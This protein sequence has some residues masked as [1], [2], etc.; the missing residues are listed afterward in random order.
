[1]DIATDHGNGAGRLA[2]I[3]GDAPTAVRRGNSG[4]GLWRRSID[5]AHRGQ[6]L[7]S[8]CR[9]TLLLV[10]TCACEVSR[11]CETLGLQ[12]RRH[13][14]QPQCVRAEMP[15][16]ARGPHRSTAPSTT[17]ALHRAHPSAA[18]Q[19]SAQ[20]CMPLS[21]SSEAA[22]VLRACFAHL[23]PCPIR[24]R[25]GGH[26]AVRMRC[27]T[28]T[29]RS[30][31]SHHCDSSHRQRGAH[32]PSILAPTAQT[33]PRRASLFLDPR[34]QPQTQTQTAPRMSSSFPFP[35][36]PNGGPMTPPPSLM[37]QKLAAL[38]AKP[39]LY[40]LGSL[41][42]PLAVACLGAM[43]LFHSALVCA[44]VEAIWAWALYL[45]FLAFDY[46][47]T[48]QSGSFGG[49]VRMDARTQLYDSLVRFHIP[50]HLGLV[51]IRVLMM[52]AISGNMGHTSAR[53]GRWVAGLNLGYACL[54]WGMHRAIVSQAE[55]YRAKHESPEDASPTAL[56]LQLY[57]AAFWFAGLSLVSIVWVP[58][59]AS[60]LRA[61]EHELLRTHA[62]SS[63]SGER[64][65]DAQMKQHRAGHLSYIVLQ[66]EKDHADP[67]SEETNAETA[68]A[69]AAAAAVAPTPPGA[70]SNEV[71]PAFH[72]TAVVFLHG[73]GAG[74]SFWFLNLPP[75]SKALPQ[76]R[77]YAVDLAGMGAS[78][79]H[80]DAG[81]MAH[82]H[83]STDAEAYF[84]SSLEG[85][86]VR[87]GVQKMILV[88]HSFGGYIAGCYAM[89]Y[90]GR[91]AHLILASPVGLPV[92]EPLQVAS[93]TSRAPAWLQ[94]TGLVGVLRWLWSR[95][96]TLSEVLHFLGPLG[97]FAFQWV[98]RRRFGHL[99][100]A[101]AK[102]RKDGTISP[103]GI[104]VYSM[105]R[106]L[107]A[108]NA[109]PCPGH[110][111]LSLLLL[112]GA[113]AVDPLVPRLSKQL[114]NHTSL[115][116]GS[117]DWMD[118]GAGEA[119]VAAVRARTGETAH[120]QGSK[121]SLCAL[122]AKPRGCPHRLFCPIDP[123]S[124]I[125]V[126]SLLCCQVEAEVIVIPHAGHQLYL[127]NPREF[128][129]TIVRIVKQAEAREGR[130]N[131]SASSSSDEKQQPA[132]DASAA[133]SGSS[134]G[135][136]EMLRHRA[137]KQ[138]AAQ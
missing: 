19:R 102:T 117:E 14:A 101:R 82:C 5:G 104:D 87:V 75:I 110:R 7:R 106:Y 39:V 135:A 113:H 118:Q 128:N 78:A 42:V 126:L 105:A 35:S 57:A 41:C 76:A 131:G 66:H 136:S 63:G 62:A 2:E 129:A 4:A 38:R 114:R 64:T 122:T 10:E 8:R 32:S 116:Y 9:L 69:T 45:K 31:H 34:T 84:V 121:V 108:I 89:R 18:R 40:A 21:H 91:V 79:L 48:V 115:I 93:P 132:A 33:A 111:G 27:A 36:A 30:T 90:P 44:A 88:G 26:C 120:A 1:M 86:R 98:V 72:G 71:A 103:R 17:V 134:L 56:F 125:S 54:V 97:S 107:Y 133:S 138:P 99:D 85:W 68:A 37:A 20:G 74:K 124:L 12:R 130:N 65:L 94:R 81:S 22:G 51:S 16:N 100:A 23:S 73:Y 95:H 109:G 77:I 83:T 58:T 112:P 67:G 52:K 137:S 15:P 50:C 55:Q 70:L 53:K 6:P 60:R 43:V 46:S 92:P 61:A 80:D 29:R 123:L 127:E 119:V 11:S 47:R 96:V 24:R 59:S 13:A 49:V 28:G 25:S 3:E